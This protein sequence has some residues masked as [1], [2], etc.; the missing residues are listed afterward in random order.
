M[1]A[2]GLVPNT[3]A[4]N[5]ALSACAKA[6][7]PRRM[8]TGMGGLASGGDRCRARFVRAFVCPV[9]LAFKTAHSSRSH[10]WLSGPPFSNPTRLT[11]SF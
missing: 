2:L 8:R 9:A 6:K 3:I 11:L 10:G 5:A 1:Q 4:H 7:D